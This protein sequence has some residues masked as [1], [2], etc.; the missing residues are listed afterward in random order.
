MGWF[1]K[2]DVPEEL[3]DLSIGG[4]GLTD[5]L[6]NVQTDKGS[7]KSYKSL[8]VKKSFSGSASNSR[9]S[10][11]IEDDEQGYFK[12]LVKRCNGWIREF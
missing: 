1:K 5:S 9:K 8:P 2:K 4:T 12:D 6:A 3:P 11:L 10:D 7:E